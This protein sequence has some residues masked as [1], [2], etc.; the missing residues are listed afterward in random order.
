MREST[1]RL[2]LRGSPPLVA[3]TRNEG[4]SDA[5]WLELISEWGSDGSHPG[6]VIELRIETFLSRLVWLAPACRRHGV[7]LDWTEALIARVEQSRRERSELDVVLDGEPAL[8]GDAVNARLRGSRFDTEGRALRPFQLR[9]VGKLLSMGHGANFSVPGTGKTTAAYATY[10]AERHAGRVQRLLG[11]APLS[12]FDAWRN[13]GEACFNAGQVPDIGFVTNEVPAGT[14]VA[15]V[16]YHRLT[17]NYAVLADWVAERPTMVLLDEAH[18]MKRGWDGQWGSACLN[19][20]FLAERRDILTGT[21]APQGPADLLAL[22]DFVWPGQ[23]RRILP[24]SALETPPPPSIGRIIGE[25]VRP[26]FVRT[27]KS[28]LGLLEPQISV[29]QV[30]PDRLQMAIYDSLRDQY[31]GELNVS[32]GDRVQLAQFGDIVMYLLEAATNPHLLSA[33][34]AAEDTLTFRHPPLE[35][36]SG[37]RLWELLQQYNQYETP[38]KFRTLAQ[39]VADN[40][41]GGRKTLVWSNFVRNLLALRRMFG[42]FEPALIYGAIPS[43]SSSPE[44]DLTRE[45]ELDRFRNDPN[46]MVLLANPASMSEGVSL[47]MT[48]HDAIYLERTF[49]AGQYLQSLDRIHRLGLAPDVETRVSLLVANG[50]IDEVV[51]SRVR[52]KAGRL[53]EML[54]DPDLET[55]ALPDDEDYGPAI[56]THDD[57][58]ALFAHLRGERP[59]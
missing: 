43:E 56:D 45:T 37:S 28:E 4:V 46:C 36:P 29:V 58:V 6:R 57:L 44:A 26:L 13:E 22:L 16:N 47:H 18:R 10:E 48:C 38:T 55:M 42:A 23:A 59:R 8:D 24:R 52:L 7:S 3:A 19:L 34:S 20:A 31:A 51:D 25:R 50:T 30:E 41:A 2:E 40:A 17:S 54:E 35:I 39:M 53:G 49:N 12:A 21:P 33:G 5:F 27:R 1:L 15:L 14:E 32:I 9:D 11:V